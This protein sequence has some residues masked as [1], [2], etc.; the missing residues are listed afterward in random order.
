[1][2]E[3]RIHRNILL[4]NQSQNKPG[5]E[6]PLTMQSLWKQE[7]QDSNLLIPDYTRHRCGP[8]RGRGATN[9]AE[10]VEAG[11]A[12]LKPPDP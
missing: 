3:L 6:E 8:T 7:R 4:H 5:G 1:M 2:D 10:P 12:G 9:C 11:E